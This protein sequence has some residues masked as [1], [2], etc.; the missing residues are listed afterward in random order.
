[1]KIL[2]TGFDPFGGESI[3]PAE[4]AVK[5]LKDEI[6]GAKIIK[7][8]IPTVREKSLKAIEEAIQTYNP[9]IVISIG[10]AGG[11]F[12]I[13]PER[14]A[15]NIDDFRITDNE[16]NQP[17]DEAVRVDGEIAYI[18]SLPVKAMV[19]HMKEN[20]IPASVSYT[21]GTF[22]CNHVMYGVLYMIDKKYPN[23]KGGFIHIPYT[24]S[25]VL[26]KR[27]MA[28]MSLDEIVKG[29]ELAIEACTMYKEDISISGGEI[30]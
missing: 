6:N 10:Q 8:T 15:I 3:N 16:G 26:D 2:I 20:G 12:D 14:I 23:I 9:D 24:T 28:Y 5:R 18:T 4:E 19:E 7:L 21:A 17:T 27:N 29:L 22:V 25:Q 11:R 1:M 13:T 30:C